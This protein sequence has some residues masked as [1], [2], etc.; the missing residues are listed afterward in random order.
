MRADLQK[1]T[2]IIIISYG[3][4]AST[5]TEPWNLCCLFMAHLLRS[6]APHLMIQ[7]NCK[8]DPAAQLNRL[9]DDSYKCYPFFA[10]NMSGLFNYIFKGEHYKNVYN[11]GFPYTVRLLSAWMG[12]QPR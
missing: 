12:K 6:T 2:I 11:H 10:E 4:P 7:N 9:L 8:V 3:L 5:H 1:N